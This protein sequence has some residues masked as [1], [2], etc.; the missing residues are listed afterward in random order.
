MC[1]RDRGDRAEEGDEVA[2]ARE[3]GGDS[4]PCVEGVPL[5]PRGIILAQLGANNTIG[6]FL[7]ANTECS[8]CF[9]ADGMGSICH[10]CFCGY[11]QP[12]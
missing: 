6:N 2:D 7:L 10:N 9:V 8:H 1:I 4:Q 5:F 3:V 12:K 11:V